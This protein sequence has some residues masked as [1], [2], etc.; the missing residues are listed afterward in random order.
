MLRKI[1]NKLY[2]VVAH[3]FRCFAYIQLAKWKPRIVVVTGSNG[4]TTTLHLLESQLQAKARYSHHAN[5]SFGIPFDILGLQR[6]TFSPLEWLGL[7]ALAPFKAWKK[8]YPENIYIVEADCD[9]PG[10]GAFLSSLLK[11]EV[12]VW[13]NSSRTHSQYFDRVVEQGK[14]PHVD[15]AIA[16]EFGYFVAKAKKLV[17][18]NADNPQ[19][20]QQESRTS[21]KVFEI[22]EPDQLE[23]YVLKE[24]GTE[25]V[26][27]KNVY[28]FS[29]FLPKETFYSIVAARK[30]LEYFGLEKE[31][32]FSTLV[33]PPGRS[34]I[35]QGIKNTTIIDSSY[36]ANVDSV[37]VILSMVKKLPANKKWAIL[38]DL[39]EQGNQEQVEHEKL[40]DLVAGVGFQRVILVGP[41]LAHY[42]LP[43]LRSL[44]GKETVVESFIQPKEALDYLLASLE[45]NE[46][47][48]FKGARFLE[49]IIEH[50]LANA[51]DVNK[52]CRREV[53]WQTRRKQWGL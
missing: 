12:V 7:F 37:A 31:H 9:R 14:F 35:L 15:E 10:E 47:L 46:T 2:F 18:L 26:I 28:R 16:F 32:N 23:Q 19:I 36:N 21:A 20:E 48:V 11:P 52:L 1:K 41:R 51:Q 44:V 4:K 39:T 13:L 43:K 53:V 24:S 17:I 3:Y 38:G 6:K 33:L 22:K 49:G 45:G 34:S 42:T 29:F 50:L 8:P 40:A 27:Q 5:S 25:F 30:L